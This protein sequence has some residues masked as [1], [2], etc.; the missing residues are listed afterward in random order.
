MVVS[1]KPL[2]ALCSNI[3]NIPARVARVVVDIAFK[4]H[5]PVLLKQ[6]I[7]SLVSCTLLADDS[8]AGTG[9]FSLIARSW[10]LVGWSWESWLAQILAVPTLQTDYTV[11]MWSEKPLKKRSNSENCLHDCLYDLIIRKYVW[12]FR[13]KTLRTHILSL[14]LRA[15]IA[16]ET[17]SSLAKWILTLNS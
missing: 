3:R 2:P 17:S 10:L 15:S 1:V 7:T 8:L 16:S 6:F 4:W 11:R 9:R 13:L 5:I 14:F 12:W